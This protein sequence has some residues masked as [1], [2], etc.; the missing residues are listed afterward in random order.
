M[1]AEVLARAL[2]AIRGRVHKKYTGL[3]CLLHPPAA[4]HLRP[5]PPLRC[6]SLTSR[7]SCECQGV[8]LHKEC[9]HH[10]ASTIKHTQLYCLLHPL[11]PDTLPTATPPPC[12]SLK[13]WE[14][15]KCFIVLKTQGFHGNH[16]ARTTH[17]CG[18]SVDN[19]P[20]PR[21]ATH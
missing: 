5:L 9:H 10:R 12:H 17:G 14:S 4:R 15:C 1:Y 2:G 20:P 3:F 8:R 6:H 13:S 7:E 21:A 19:D 11:L 18:P 16:E